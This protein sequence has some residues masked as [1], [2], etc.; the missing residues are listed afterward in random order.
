[1][2][3]CEIKHIDQCLLEIEGRKD[4]IHVVKDGYQVIDYLFE[5]GDTFAT[6]IRQQCRGIKFDLDGNI[7][8]RPLHK[9]FNYGQKLLTYDWSKPHR[10]MTKLD[11]CCD[12]ETLITT[13]HG[14]TTIREIC[15]NNYKGPILGYNHHS[16]VFEWVNIIDTLIQENNDDWYQITLENGVTVKL[17]GNH[18]VWVINKSCYIRVDDLSEED[19]LLLF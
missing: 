11:G 18:Q 6:P 2:S 17:T 12:G 14:D 10:I 5:D 8:G 15:E 16:N 13:I 1:M 19:E 9:F 7:I 3:F 4:F